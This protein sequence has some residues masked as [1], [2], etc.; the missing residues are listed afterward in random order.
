MA[1]ERLIDDDKDRKYKIRKNADGEE[2]LVIDESGEE[3]GVEIPVFEVPYADED[4]E[5]AAVLTPEQYAERERIKKEEEEARAKRAE[6]LLETAKQKLAAGDMEGAQY[7]VSRAEEYLKNG[8]VY[9]LMLKAYTR[10][11]HDYT[12]LEY[13]KTAADG[14]KAHASTE[15]KADLKK[16]SK[17]LKDKIAEVKAASDDLSA[18][19]EEKK[20]ERREFFA[21]EKKKAQN[22]FL[23]AVV[24]FVALAICA[25]VLATNMFAAENGAFLIATIVVAAFAAVALVFT[26]ITARKFLSSLRNVRLNE[27]DS[28]TKLGREYEKS[29]KLLESLNEILNSFEENDI[30]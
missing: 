23:G 10:N 17:G 15:Q 20:T 5:D 22:L 21:A 14:V 16:C 24:P 4:D 27:K 29:K 26:L 25:I 7:D 1:E 30:S 18:R 11:F 19:N 12:A 28:A 3:D 6:Q 2:E 8:E 13:A 9:C